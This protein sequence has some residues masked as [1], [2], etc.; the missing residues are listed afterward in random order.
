MNMEA[1]IRAVSQEGDTW[2]RVVAGPFE[3]RTLVA[4][5]RDLLVR[6]GI[7]PIMLRQEIER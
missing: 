1:E 2:H 4:R 3:S 6:E 7:H 5:A